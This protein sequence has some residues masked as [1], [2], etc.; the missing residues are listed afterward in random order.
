MLILHIFDF[1]LTFSFEFC[2]FHLE[3]FKIVETFMHFDFVEILAG[4][5]I[6]EL[7][8]DDFFLSLVFFF[9]CTDLSGKFLEFNLVV[10]PILIY[11][12]PRILSFIQVVFAIVSQ[13]DDVVFEQIEIISVN[14]SADLLE[15]VYVYG[16]LLQL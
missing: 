6:S 7:A 4:V 14:V 13:L 10:C 8:L 1:F 16:V 5:E 2:Q 15:E 9:F 3:I 12:I 11:F